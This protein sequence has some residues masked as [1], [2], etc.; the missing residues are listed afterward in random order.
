MNVGS[1]SYG[2]SNICDFITNSCWVGISQ[3]IIVWQASQHGIYQQF[4][5][6]VVTRPTTKSYY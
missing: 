4:K 1:K 2:I 3:S 6:T 5:M